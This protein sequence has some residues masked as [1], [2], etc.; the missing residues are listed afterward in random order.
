M[1]ARTSHRRR[2]HTH[3]HSLHVFFFSAHKIMNFQWVLLILWSGCCC[4][5]SGIFRCVLAIHFLY[6]IESVHTFCTLKCTI[7]LWFSF[8]FRSEHIFT[9]KFRSWCVFFQFPLLLM[10]T[11]VSTI[12]STFFF[13][14]ALWKMLVAKTRVKKKCAKKRRRS[15][16]KRWTRRRCWRR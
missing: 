16:K 15:R 9:H 13:F 5:F 6:D 7:F 4:R 2:P 3:T 12:F 8:F 1:N 11:I 14:F 10:C